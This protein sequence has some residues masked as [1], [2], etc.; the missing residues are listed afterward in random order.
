MTSFP[1]Q[2]EILTWLVLCRP[3]TGYHYYDLSWVHSPVKSNR[4]CFDH[5]LWILKSF[6]SHFGMFLKPLKKEVCYICL[7][8][9]GI[10]NVSFTNTRYDWWKKHL[11]RK[12]ALNIH[13]NRW[14]IIN[15]RNG[16]RK[17]DGRRDRQRKVGKET[18]K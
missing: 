15:M 9:D 2:A 18:G 12:C 5:V 1:F 7:M 8:Y 6:C 4:Y 13:G 3:Y 17:D 16:G 14:H 10:M 11:S